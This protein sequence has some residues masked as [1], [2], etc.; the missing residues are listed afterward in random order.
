[1]KEYVLFFFFLIL[2]NI[3]LNDEQQE[4][5]PTKTIEE[6]EKNY[7]E[8]RESTVL[9]QDRKLTERRLCC[10]VIEQTA[11]DLSETCE[12]KTTK[13]EQMLLVGSSITINKEFSGLR[14]Y[15][16]EYGGIEGNYTER[17]EK[18]QRTINIVCE[19]WRFDVNIIGAEYTQR[20]IKILQSD[21]H[22][23]SYFTPYL[24]HISSTRRE[25]TREICYKAQLLGS[26]RKQGLSC[27]YME[28]NIQEGN[29]ITETRKTCYIYDPNI[30]ITKKLD[31]ATR[32]TLDDL[33]TKS[34]NPQ[35]NYKFSIYGYNGTGFTGF[36]YDSETGVVTDAEDKSGFDY[37]DFLLNNDLNFVEEEE[38]NHGNNIIINLF[39]NHCILL[40]ILFLL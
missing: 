13:E 40:I 30:T 10:D 25:I 21:N 26:T 37:D 27:G 28:I 8:D 29:G 14:I 34:Q 22:C 6:D 17:R 23:L 15:N 11:D 12:V 35:F 3:A 7:C 1:M 5:D 16:Q 33:S 31:E 32:F 38:D 24:Y 20:E 39:S 18:I 36:S 4:Y 19:S 9:C 2:F